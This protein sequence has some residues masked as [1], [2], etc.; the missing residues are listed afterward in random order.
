MVRRLTVLYDPSCEFCRRCR[1]WLASQAT[2]VELEFL[3]RANPAA[4]E[5]FGRIEA[6]PD[7]LVVVSD[8]GAVYRGPK[9]FIVCLYALRDYRSW[10]FRLAQ[11]EMQP[12]AG[13]VLDWLSHNRLRLGRWLHDPEDEAFAAALGPRAEGRC[14]QGRCG[15]SEAG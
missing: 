9:A 13:R 14:I 11:P 1:R 15:D 3:G 6:A 4:E 8:E 10:A 5:R 7:E 2:L 12:L